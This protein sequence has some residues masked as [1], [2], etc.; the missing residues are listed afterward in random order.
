MTRHVEGTAAG[1]GR[2]F[3]WGDLLRQ[4]V[5][6]TRRDWRAGELTLL[7]VALVLA[8]AALTSVGFLADRLRQG[9]ERDARQMIGA[10]FIVRGD[11]PLDPSFTEQAR[12]LGLR[13]AT[14]A[15][16]PSMVGTPGADGASRLAAVK[17]VSTGYP[18]RGAVELEDGANRPARPAAAIPAPGTVWADPAL[19]D[20]LHLRVGDPLRVGSRTFVV[21]AAIARELDRGFSF[22]N[23]SPR[24]MLRD[25]ELASTG[26][27]AYGSRVTYRLLVA[28]GEAAI[29]RFERY[30][31]ARVDGGRLRGVALE[32]LREGQPQVRQTL[33]RARHF[34][35]LVALLT[36]LLAAVAIA[37]AAQRYMRRHLD[38]CAA[39]RC[40]GASRRTLGALF[41]IEFT[42]LGL[43][44]GLLGA[45]LG[46]A[47]H[48]VLLGAL[49]SLIEVALPAPT[50]WPAA[51]GIAAGLVLL[52]G[53][54]LPP[55]VPLTRV[56]PVR[57]LRREW[58]DAARIA[59]LG[60]GFG[61][62]LFAGLLILAAG[63]LKLGLI[64]AGG[65]AGG[66]V[67]FALLARLALLAGARAVR[68]GRVA[69]GFGWRYALA[70]LHR[71]G[72]ASALQITALALGLMCLLLISVTRN[73]LVA[74][75]RQSTPPDAPNQF[76]IDIQPDQ[77][78]AVAAYLGAHG[79]AAVALEPMVRGRLVAVNGKPVNPDDYKR[80][81]ARRLVDREFN[82]SYTTRL[83]D[84]NRIT[85]G[86]W[87]GAT[88]T[89][90]IS[91]E[92]GL[93]KTL[94]VQ[95][96]DRLRFDVTGLTVEAPVT[97]VRKLDWGSFKV[98]FFVLMPPAALRDFPAT[99]ITSF[100]LPPGRQR[101]LD[102]LIVQYP[103]ITAI[104]I[105]PILA[106]LQRVLLQVIGAVQFLF[107]FT[108]AA[109]VLVL[110]AALAGTRDERMREAALLRALGASR[111]QVGAVQ[112]AEFIVVGVLAGAMAAA[113]AIAIGSVLATRVFDFQL[114]FNPWLVPAGIAAGV[115]CA[116]LAGWLGLRRVLARPAL[117]SLRDA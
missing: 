70:S 116:G 54:A 74:G 57:V 31:H 66:L 9:L 104:D 21:S 89:P 13:T 12:A 15:V 25:D 92:A 111:A 113:G 117:Q 85:A 47:G 35:T 60:Y 46:Y 69:A 36:A 26:L 58:G 19:L 29:G 98:N 16:F 28:G 102:S 110:Y 91:I 22:V 4:A 65:F 95:P 106:Q 109:G 10:D 49:G 103:N 82:L 87:Y 14:T 86:A 68:G 32:S 96:G 99:Y 115:A 105:A 43:V 33:D 34:L 107:G 18:L 88:D 51:V 94:G 27:I 108:L 80:D 97:S 76:L 41:A 30:A 112:R 2:R 38:G 55:L 64:V 67:L 93:A 1:R 71:R 59:W 90:Q 42:L 24:V 44:G 73:D 52:L 81:D 53:F 83:P 39:M 6:M 62:A 61:V 45:A 72:A 3:G 40:L 56:P 101:A 79:V 48:R 5:R 78:D 114:V 20:A 37:M 17:A 11:R 75:W 63:N 7:I 8:V 100:H 23:F 84:D 50:V 77:H